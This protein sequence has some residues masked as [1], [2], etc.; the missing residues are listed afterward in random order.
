L[1]PVQPVSAAQDDPPPQVQRVWQLQGRQALPV[2]RV[3]VKTS[4]A[5]RELLSSLT[6]PILRD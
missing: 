5:F 4:Q 1:A 2:S 6:E 3:L